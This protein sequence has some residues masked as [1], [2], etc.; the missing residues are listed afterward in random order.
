[1]RPVSRSIEGRAS[2]RR[3]RAVSAARSAGEGP[4]IAGAATRRR[5]V[6]VPGSACFRVQRL[7]AVSCSPRS[8][9]TAT[10]VIA[11]VAHPLHRL[12]PCTPRGTRAAVSD[13]SSRAPSRPAVPSRKRPPIRGRISARPWSGFARYCNLPSGGSAC[14]GAAC[15][16]PARPGGGDPFRC[17]VERRHDHGGA[18]MDG[19]R[20]AA[21]GALLEHPVE[22]GARRRRHGLRARLRAGDADRARAAPRRGAL[23][24]RRRAAGLRPAAT[25]PSASTRPR[26]RSRLGSPRPPV[27]RARRSA[28][29]SL[30]RARRSARAVMPAVA[31]RS[32]EGVSAREAEGVRPR[33]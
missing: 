20:D 30:G 6:I 8:S 32:V 21:V 13:P 18:R 11:H 16:C 27:M 22:H 25:R 5:S 31:E 10:S 9:A 28:P 12:A 7:S 2:S 1:M 3:G 26:A 17:S 23:R 24:A 14:G 19:Q 15:P 33:G 4:A 29:R